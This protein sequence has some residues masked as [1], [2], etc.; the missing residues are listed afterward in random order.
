[1]NSLTWSIEWRRT[2]AWS[3][4]PSTGTRLSVCPVL[5]LTLLPPHPPFFLTMFFLFS[6]IFLLSHFAPPPS[7]PPTAQTHTHTHFLSLHTSFALFFRSFSIDLCEEEAI[8]MVPAALFCSSLP[9]CHVLF[10]WIWRSLWYRSNDNDLIIPWQ[11]SDNDHLCPLCQGSTEVFHDARADPVEDA[12]PELW[13][14]A[15]DRLCYQPSHPCLQP[16]TGERRQ[17][18]DRPQEQSGGT[19]EWFLDVSL[20]SHTTCLS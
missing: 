14:G 2:S 17:E 4:S 10:C 8:L 18:V 7:P 19:C 11:W 12:V 6:P 13:D 1:M 3:R 9:L 5:A 20:W 15:Q 16:Q